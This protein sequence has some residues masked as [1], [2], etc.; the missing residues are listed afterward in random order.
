[1]PGAKRK[2]R[3]RAS[4]TRCGTA[5]RRRC[6]PCRWHSAENQQSHHADAAA[7]AASPG[8]QAMQQQYRA[9]GVSGNGG[10]GA[11]SGC[12]GSSN[13]G[14]DVIPSSDSFRL[15]NSG[16]KAGKWLTLSHPGVGGA[17]SRQKRP[18]DQGY[19]PPGRPVG[20][21]RLM[22]IG[23]SQ[24]AVGGRGGR[25]SGAVAAADAPEVWRHG[26]AAGPLR[27]R[28]GHPKLHDSAAAAGQAALA[29][30]AAAAAVQEGVLWQRGAPTDLTMQ[31]RTA[32]AAVPAER[33]AARSAV[34]AFGAGSG[35]RDG[36]RRRR[37]RSRATTSG[38]VPAP[39]AA[40]SQAS[41]RCA[42]TGNAGLCSGTTH[43]S[44]GSHARC[45]CGRAVGGGGRGGGRRCACPGC[46][47]SPASCGRTCGSGGSGSCS[48]SC[49]YGSSSG[50]CA[51]GGGTS[52]GWA[53]RGSTGTYTSSG[54]AAGGGGGRC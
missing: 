54:G 7:A 2:G 36:M 46:S 31:M 32:A 42:H 6:L 51:S 10:S 38:A 45:G 18:A 19:M 28:W 25:G 20:K 34:A 13:S 53:S 5:M 39:D 3:Q 8:S 11:H 4:C 29:V 48:C 9:P 26:A 24:P 15:G 35:L 43:G 14:S 49:T 52:G 50:H 17:A 41:W 1:M 23:S 40:A 21:R 12:G 16:T 22:D 37:R 27:S 44:R 30:G 47:R 33:A